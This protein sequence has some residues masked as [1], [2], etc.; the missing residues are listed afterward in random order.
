MI[1]MRSASR[2]ASSSSCVAS[3][4]AQPLRSQVADDAADRVAAVD[5]DARCRLVEEGDLGFGGQR[6]GQRQ[7]AAARRPTAAATSPCSWRSARPP[8][9]ARPRRRRCRRARRSGAPSPAPRAR[10]DAAL[11]QHH[12]HALAELALLR[13]PGRSRAL[14]RCQ[15]SARRYPSQTSIVDVLPAPFGPSTV[16]TWPAAAA[17]E[18]PSTA[19]TSPWRT[20]RCSTSTAATACDPRRR[21]GEFAIKSLRD[22]TDHWDMARFSVV[23][24]ALDEQADLGRSLRA[25]TRAAQAIRTEAEVVVVV[26][27][28]DA[29]HAHVAQLRRVRRSSTSVDRTLR[30]PATPAPR[31]ATGQIL[32]TIDADRVMSPVAFA[33]IERLLGNRLLCRWR[34]DPACPSGI[35]CRSMWRW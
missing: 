30:W 31:S 4:T 10:V 6:Q 3:T 12:A 11:L 17:N 21:P 29:A 33:E 16:V 34:S 35:R 18:M 2:S 19:T 20:V 26:R 9:R 13:S 24:S 14:A 32:V 27:D 22:S 8:R 7:R 23:V 25:I 28:R 1:T 5:V 15:R